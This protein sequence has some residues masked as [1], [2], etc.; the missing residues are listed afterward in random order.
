MAKVSL[1]TDKSETDFRRYIIEM[2][3]DQDTHQD[4]YGNCWNAIRAKI[5]ED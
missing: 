5:V 4:S 2:N 1:L 3:P